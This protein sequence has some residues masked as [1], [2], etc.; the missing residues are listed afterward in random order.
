MR[1]AANGALQKTVE[2]L[3]YDD[4]SPEA[5]A[6]WLRHQQRRLPSVSRDTIHRY[7]KSPY[8]R[9]VEAYRLRRRKRKGRKRSTTGRLADRTFVDKRPAYINDRSRIGDSEGDFVVSGKNGHGVLLVIVDR[10]A[11][12]AFLERILRPACTAVTDATQRIKERYPEWK[13]M[14]TDNDILFQHHKELA[15]TLGIK[16]Y[17]CHPYH[18]WEKGSVENTNKHI[19]K[20]IP[21]GSDLSRYGKPF[22]KRLEAKLNRRIMKC[23]S[24][25]T[26]TEVLTVHRKRK[27][28]SRA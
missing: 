1:I 8:G 2:A 27:K 17:F 23:L 20:T 4:Q 13:T 10:K 16:I 28:R 6:G 5:I 14:T 15:E 12:T 26:P 3:L 19:R 18:S 7:I 25:R 22:I 11:R 21:K 9:R 24:Y